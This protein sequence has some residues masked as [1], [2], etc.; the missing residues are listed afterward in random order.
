MEHLS[1]IAL[2][3]KLAARRA[4]IEMVQITVRLSALPLSDDL[5]RFDH[6]FKLA[7]TGVKEK[8]V[9][10]LGPFGAGR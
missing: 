3:R 4:G 5:S 1:Q 6:D 10:I 8:A 7:V 9:L 2:V